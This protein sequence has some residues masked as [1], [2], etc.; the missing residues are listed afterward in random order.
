MTTKKLLRLTIISSRPISW[1]NTAFPFAAG[2]LVTGGTVNAYFWI[3]LFYFLVPYNFLIYIVNDIYDYESDR[4]NPR[5]NS[6]E[7]GILPPNTHRTML[8][9][10]IV[11][12]A[13]ILCFLLVTGS[14]VASIVLLTIVLGAVSYSMPPLRLKERPILDSVNSSFHFVGP[15]LFALVLTGWQSVYLPYILSFFFWGIASHAFG[16]VQDILPDRKARIKSI[17]TYLGASRTVRFSLIMYVLSGI[18]L[19]FAGWPAALICVPLLLYVFM[20]LPYIHCADKDSYQANKGWRKFL[21]INQLSGFIITVI[22]LVAY[23][24][25]L[26]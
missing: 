23:L 16:A 25:P 5:K 12:N 11:F 1:I 4:T 26:L 8:L 10:T 19:L 3:A 13:I 9:A 14:V 2:Y 15:L 20:V 22:L 24:T 6:I 7:G 18:C 21:W 17:A